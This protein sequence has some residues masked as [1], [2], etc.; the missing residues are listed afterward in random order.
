MVYDGKELQMH[1]VLDASVPVLHE[2]E[3]HFQ[4]LWQDLLRPRGHRVTQELQG[5]EEL[6]AFAL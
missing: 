3:Q 5:T 1:E 6:C 4:K 2:K